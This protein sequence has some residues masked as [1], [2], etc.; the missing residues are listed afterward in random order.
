MPSGDGRG[1]GVGS[2]VTRANPLKWPDSMPESALDIAFR[3]ADSAAAHIRERTPL[4]PKIAIVLG[5]GLGGFANRLTDTV[6]IP[7]T[8]IPPFPRSTVEGHAGRLVIGSFAGT[9]L[10]VMQGRVHAYEGYTPRQVIYPTQVLA[11]LGI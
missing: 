7:Y 8:E 2:H 10:A 5:T 11:R 1:V 6:A 9:P 3:Q 4:Q